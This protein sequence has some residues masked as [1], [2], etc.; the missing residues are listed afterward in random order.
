MTQKL[1]A[2]FGIAVM[3]AILFGGLTISQSAFAG[4]GGGGG[5]QKVTICHQG[6]EGPET[7]TVAAPA[8]PAHL[9]HGDTLGPCVEE[10]VTC[11]E[12]GPSA[13]IEFLQCID[14]GG[15]NDVC[16]AQVEP[17]LT[18]CALMC[19]GSELDKE[20][21][22]L[23]AAIIQFNICLASGEDGLV[24]EGDATAFFDE[25]AGVPLPG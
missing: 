16:T 9:N 14:D 3:A 13:E 25:C 11:L 7:I 8:I 24:C 4:Q 20:E 5:Q 2:I 18:E 17:S 19:E 12:C 21:A 22:C 15:T 6:D 1:T 10:P 23:I